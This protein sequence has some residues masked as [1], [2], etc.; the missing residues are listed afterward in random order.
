MIIAGLWLGSCLQKMYIIPYWIHLLLL[1]S[2][3]LY[4]G[5]HASLQLRYDHHPSA[6]PDGS[7]K[8]DAP[9]NQPPPKD[10]M[11]R[12]D[13]YQFP[14]IGSL[15]LFSLYLAFKFLD[16]E[17]VNFI[18]GGYFGLMGCTAIAMTLA[19]FLPEFSH[20]RW[21]RENLHIKHSLTFL[22]GPS[23]LDLSFA[24]TLGDVLA[25]TIAVG[26]MVLYFIGGK[27]WYLN[28]AIGICFCLQ[29]MQKFSLGTYQIGAILLAGLFL[30]DIF[31]VF[32]T[33]V[34]VT[35][36]KS[37]DGP[38]KL[39]FPREY[40]PETDKYELSLLGL[41]DIVIPGFFL[42]LLLRFDARHQLPREQDEFS[43]TLLWQHMLS[44]FPKPYFHTT[45]VAYVIGLATTLFVMNFFQAAQP[46]LLY[47]VPACLGGSFG[48]ALFR[49][50]VGE[51]FQYSEEEEGEETK[52]DKAKED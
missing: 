43:T 17:W 48:C 25:F 34:M 26:T 10:V 3:I 36:A 28:N 21:E 46:A 30:Y 38:I 11:S 20:L 4:A 31:W 42:A 32:G 37:L 19:Q 18:I 49:K 23:P 7:S 40:D 45:L 1:V 22:L 51:L 8:D 44:S 27:P 52:E 15:S 35:V 9:I 24:I 39:L 16:K 14:L 33:E 12:Q 41:G 2:A 50:E 47:L 13:A 29:A 5:C 6:H